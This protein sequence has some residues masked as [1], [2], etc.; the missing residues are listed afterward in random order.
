MKQAPNTKPAVIRKAPTRANSTLLPAL[1]AVGGGLG[2]LPA[3]ALEL[4]RLNVQSTL[5]EPL[6]ASIAYALGPNEALADY[7]ISLRPASSADSLP[8]LRQAD[9]RVG[10]GVIVLSGR[11]AL[12]EP[13]M[14][15]R[16]GIDCPYTPRLT[17]EYTLL[18]DPPG[19]QSSEVRVAATPARQPAA[20]A[21]PA[22]VEPAPR[23]LAPAPQK[24][25]APIFEGT[26]YRVQPGDTLSQ[27]AADIENRPLGLWA[28]VNVIFEA[29]PD[30]FIDNDPNLLKAG[31]W[32]SIPS[33]AET[34]EPVRFAEATGVTTPVQSIDG[35]AYEDADQVSKNAGETPLESSLESSSGSLSETSFESSFEYGDQA[36]D[37]A[38]ETAAAP[39]AAVP[40]DRL[41]EAPTTR[42][43]Q[44][45][46]DSLSGGIKL[47]EEVADDSSKLKPGDVVF[48]ENPYI[49][50]GASVN[51]APEAD[52]WTSNWLWWLAGS[53]LALI[54]ALLFFGRRLREGFG[55][56]PLDD[57]PVNPMRRS[58]D[59]PAQ[60]VNVHDVHAAT[61]NP[62]EDA[63]R[64]GDDAPT[65]ENTV[66][67]ADLVDGTGLNKGIEVEVNEDFAFETS[68][69][70]DFELPQDAE[71]GDS[72]TDVIPAPERSGRLE[73]I[74]DSEVLPEDNDYDMSVIIDATKMPDPA[75]ATERDFKAVEVD[76]KPDNYTISQEID[77]KILEQDYEDELT[78]T[79]V[80]NDEIERAAAELA[81]RMETTDKAA[82][83]N[84]ATTEMQFA[85]VTELDVTPSVRAGNDDRD[86]AAGNTT[87]AAARPAA[88]DK[89]VE[90]P[91]ADT[92]RT[93]EMPAADTDRTVE[94]PAAGTDRTVEMPAAETDRTVEMPAAET[95]GTV[96]FVPDDGEQ[97]MEMEI[98][99]GRV[100]TKSGRG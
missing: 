66:L 23:P 90:M 36:T 45:T 48:D 82:E 44:A 5:G 72:E 81:S 40:T 65:E 99:S 88:D 56:P 77:Y 83:D 68:T 8:T 30:A 60:A 100:N 37:V 15:L 57:A 67:D 84:E 26:R 86:E 3:T 73:S 89:T 24:M 52:T 46:I 75:D 13:L 71:K 55:A 87:D 14:M 53:G 19:R 51:A 31:S 43:T 50:P 97:T 32:L 16:L 21:A 85:S 58:T 74:L 98:E 20:V 95:D 61:E 54:A 78:A 12:Q 27:I 7:C 63:Y 9:I 79:Q 69:N 42:E 38:V 93:V 1:V 59:D 4:G 49:A 34:G 76:D 17:R 92:A 11:R 29:N 2:A 39:Q 96:E 35:S 64:I 28:A 41:A 62:A 47:A 70:L 10:N 80:L 18:V 91:A 6:R 25:P 94:M 33:F 22:R